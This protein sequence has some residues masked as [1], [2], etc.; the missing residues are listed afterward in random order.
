MLLGVLF[1]GVVIVGKFRMPTGINAVYVLI[2]ALLGVLGQAFFTYA[3]L[4]ITARAGGLVSSSRIVFATA[5]GC[6]VFADKLTQPIVL[7]GLCILT[8]IIG[9]T[10]QIKIETRIPEAVVVPS[11]TDN[12]TR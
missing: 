11:I 7:G 9:V 10:W 8:S 6:F 2:S 4:Y 1:N 3:Y 5:L 12:S